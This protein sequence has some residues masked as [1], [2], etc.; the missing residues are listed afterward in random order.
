MDIINIVA[1]LPLLRFLTVSDMV[2]YDCKWMEDISDHVTVTGNMC[3]SSESWS[4]P[5]EG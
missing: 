3:P 5:S 1:S 2:Y 4:S